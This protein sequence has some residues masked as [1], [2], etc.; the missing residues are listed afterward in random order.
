MRLLVLGCRLLALFQG[1]G[2]EEVGVVAVV[3][4]ATME[5][6][7][8]VVAVAMSQGA[9]AGPCPLVLPMRVSS[10]KHSKPHL[11]LQN[12]KEI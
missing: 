4:V 1:T 6:V 3:V 11:A 7:M 10:G 12:S 9:V 8:E 5:G 2:V